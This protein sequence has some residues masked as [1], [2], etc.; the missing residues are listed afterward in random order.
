MSR[1][2]EVVLAS[3]KRERTIALLSEI[4]KDCKPFLKVMSNNGNP[5]WI[6]SGRVKHDDWY[7]DKVRTDR[8]PRDTH[9]EIHEDLDDM[10]RDVFGYPA[11]SASM[12]VSGDFGV[13]AQYGNEYFIFPKG[14]FKY[15]WSPDIADL[16]VNIKSTVLFTSAVSDPRF[17]SIKNPL[18]LHY[19]T[20]VMNVFPDASK[21]EILIQAKA[22]YYEHLMKIVDSYSNR[23]Y[24]A[25]TQSRR[26][27]M[28]HC[29]EYIAVNHK[30][31]KNVII[32]FFR[33]FRN[34]IPKGKEIIDW[35]DNT[36]SGK[37][38]EI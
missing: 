1:L 31:Y 37:S 4:T 2:T 18:L 6:Y 20:L 12:F 36:Y 19:I 14:N 24:G 33:F 34:A 23:D 32:R 9:P 16:Y 28:L 29:N 22:D 8:K 35:Y 13:V 27:I 5:L 11:R 30:D 7:V 26:E 38:N 3:K 17:R 15:L 25:A 10:F 21:S